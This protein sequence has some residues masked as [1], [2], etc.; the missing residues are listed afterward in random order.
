MKTSIN[1]NLFGTLYAIDED[2]HQLLRQYLDNMKSY[3]S[4]QEGG[5]EI[6]DDIEHRVAELFWELKQAGNESITIEQV[7]SIIQEIGNPED[8]G[9]S[10]TGNEAR[11]TDDGQNTNNDGQQSTDGSQQFKQEI[12]D[13]VRNAGSKTRDW[14]SHRRYYRDPQD[15]MV[16]GVLSG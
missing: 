16:G 14:M 6:S 9:G 1:I 3:F 8:L 4:K 10:Q 15:K 5:D 12:K 13:S 2:A 11:P 7:R